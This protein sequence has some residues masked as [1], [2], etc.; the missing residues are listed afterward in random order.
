MA[1]TTLAGVPRD[2]I[3]IVLSILRCGRGWSQK[4]LA[5]NSG[6]RSTLISDFERGHM[7]PT[8]KQVVRLVAAMGY[9]LAALDLSCRYLEAL[10]TDTYSLAPAVRE[11]LASLRA[12]DP[13]AAA[14]SALGPVES[15]MP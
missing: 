7:V 13:S 6:A 8:V 14:P 12:L 1:T 9:P 15:P 3:G 4:E 10:R 2:E 11:A 5:R